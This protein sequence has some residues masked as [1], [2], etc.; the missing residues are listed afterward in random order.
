MMNKLGFLSLILVG[1]SVT[2]VG[3]E[4]TTSTETAQTSQQVSQD[5]VAQSATVDAT[6]QSGAA[7]QADPT[8]QPAEPVQ[9]SPMGDETQ[10]PESAQ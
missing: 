1:A 8:L 3:C 10:S 2:M 4:S 6:A 5:T 9:V 7:V